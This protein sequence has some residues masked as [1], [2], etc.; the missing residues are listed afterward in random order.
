ML[1]AAYD[2]LVVSQASVYYRYDEFKSG[3]KS[4]ELMNGPGAPMT[5]LINNQHQ[6]NH[7][8]QAS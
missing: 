4:V 5:T 3:E 8:P 2:E 1:S 7:D 6:R